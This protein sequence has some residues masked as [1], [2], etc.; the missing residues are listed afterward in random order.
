MDFMDSSDVLIIDGQNLVQKLELVN[1][2]LN[3]QMVGA[4]LTRSEL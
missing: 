1:R 2:Y 4:A 3:Y